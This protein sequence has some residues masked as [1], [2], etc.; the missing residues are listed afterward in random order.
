MS[1]VSAV[2]ELE[3]IAWGI[4]TPAPLEDVMKKIALTLECFVTTSNEGL[5]VQ[6]GVVLYRDRYVRA[7]MQRGFITQHDY[8]NGRQKKGVFN[9]NIFGLELYRELRTEKFIK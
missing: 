1:W 6:E 7:L 9:V 2:R 4:D 8:R 3:K 5:R